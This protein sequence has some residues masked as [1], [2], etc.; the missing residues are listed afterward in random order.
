[1]A[2]KLY[3]ETSIQDIA[4]AIREKNGESTTYKVA[5]MGNAIRAIIGQQD[6]IKTDTIDVTGKNWQRGLIDGN[7]GVMSDYTNYLSIQA[8][9]LLNT[10]HNYKTLQISCGDN[11]VMR[12]GIYD[13]QYF[14]NADF[15]HNVHRYEYNITDLHNHNFDISIKKHNGDSFTDDEAMAIIETLEIKLTTGDGEL[16]WDEPTTLAQKACLARASQLR[17]IEFMP[18]GT[19][20]DL[21]GTLTAG[22]TYKGIRYSSVRDTDKFIGY[23]VSIHTYMTALNN[24]KSVLYTK[25]SEQPSAKQ[26]YGLNCSVYSSYAW[27][28][29]YLH[30]TNT[31]AETDFVEEVNPEDIML[32]DSPD[33]HA[34]FGGT[35]GHTVFITGVQRDKDGNIVTLEISETANPNTYKTLNSYPYFYERYIV[36]KKYKVFR[37]KRLHE[38]SYKPSI[39]IPL[40]NEPTETIVY[41]DLCTNLGDK[42]TILTSEKITLNP[43]VTDGYT[44]IKLY[45]NGTEINSYDVEDITLENLDVGRYTA[46]LYPFNDNASTSFIVE[47]ASISK[48]GNR[49]Y[50]NGHGHPL[51]LI[52][53][54]SKYYTLSFVDLSEK[55]IARGYVD[56]D[57]ANEKLS[58]YCVPFKNEYG[59]NLVTAEVDSTIVLAASDFTIQSIGSNGVALKDGTKNRVGTERIAIDDTKKVSIECT[60]PTAWII[61]FFSD[62]AGSDCIGKSSYTSNDIDDITSVTLASGTIEGA[63][64]FRIALRNADDTT[65]E[66]TEEMKEALVSNCTITISSEVATESVEKPNLVESSVGTDG[67]VYNSTGYKDGWRFKSS[68]GEE[69]EQSGST[70]TGFIPA[71]SGQIFY[72][73]GVTWG[74]SSDIG[75]YTAMC[76]YDSSMAY[77]SGISGN[78]ES[79]AYLVRGTEIESGDGR[80]CFKVITTDK[81]PD[82]SRVAYVRFSMAGNGAD[83]VINTD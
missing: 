82:A 13:T 28:I 63:N 31:L 32:C 49:Y 68:S 70:I 1:M 20:P 57:Y 52:F 42:A 67:S 24:P 78:A 7:G 30:T 80:Y 15:I 41:S 35:E 2:N 59:C 74:T 16:S 48:E 27:G 50:F 76:C 25:E 14:T 45:K 53:K 26:W 47:Q 75:F 22:K 5:D 18:V 69:V 51:R 17:D 37:N 12:I 39:Y 11:Y 40:E 61:Y 66:L 34:N 73:S 43:L 72:V 44:A 4:D 19:I 58:Y 9:H 81:T 36:N 62:N 55:D 65:S 60:S 79:N 23:G 71:T 77:I 29:E 83:I 21:A 64:Y 6:E 3:E 10:S 56:C 8:I 33:C 38:V 46:S 54:D